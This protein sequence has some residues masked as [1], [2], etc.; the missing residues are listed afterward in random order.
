MI[1]TVEMIGR[2]ALG[3]ALGSAIG[4]EREKRAWTAGLRTHMMV[5]LCATLIMEVSAYGFYDVIQDK[6]IVLD[7][8]RIAAQVV[9]GIGFLGAGTI[10]FLRN[11]VV[12]G[13]TTAA[14]LW[15][16]AGIGLA[17]GS[18]MYIAAVGTTA[19]A[20][21]ILL[22]FRR[23][24]EKYFSKNKFKNIKITM[25]PNQ[26]E[27]KQ[28]EAIFQN[29]R[30]NF[31]EVD[32]YSDAEE[33]TDVVKIKIQKDFA[34]TGGSLALVAEIKKLSGVKEVSFLG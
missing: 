23:I 16:V 17:A 26:L 11:E 14:G 12:K 6:L 27:F 20:L 4:W 5:C 2:L 25:R 33:K 31:T 7:P 1:T 13:L 34:K 18:G 8:S 9:S 21:L 3:A 24:E 15:A 19:I 10:V 22:L 28:I 29:H 30:I 32:L